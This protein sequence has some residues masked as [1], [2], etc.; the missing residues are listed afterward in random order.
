MDVPCL[1]RLPTQCARHGM[2]ATLLVSTSRACA[3]A[4]FKTHEGDPTTGAAVVE[5]AVPN[6]S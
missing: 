6:F 3:A 5:N 1:R 2:S 4:L